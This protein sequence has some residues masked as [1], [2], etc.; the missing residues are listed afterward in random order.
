MLFLY[1]FAMANPTS[2]FRERRARIILYVLMFYILFQLVWWGYLLIGTYK[3]LYTL[4]HE[5]SE[6]EKS[7]VLQKKIWMLLGEGAVFL[8]L[9]YIGFRYLNRSLSRELQL[10]RMQKTFLLSV[11][12]ELKTPIAAIKLFLD[13]LKTRKLTEEQTTALLNDALKETKR[14]QVL[15]ENILLAQRIEGQAEEILNEK[16]DFSAMLQSEAARYSEVFNRTIVTHIDKNIVLRGDKHLLQSVCGNLLENA[17][18]Y[19]SSDTEIKVNCNQVGDKLKIEICD[20][21]IGIPDNEK[22][23]IFKKFY[24]GGNEETRS[25]KG[26]GL[27]LYIVYSVVKLHGGQIFVTDNKPTGTTMSVVFKNIP[28]DEKQ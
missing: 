5:L 23:H 27:G 11:T 4:N 20:K 15:S 3:N 19:S 2:I 21:G 22:P 28:L 24:R 9:I 6:V 14:L 18:K 8:M 1:Q 26:T 12:H 13:T 17:V 25:H 10:A 16:V 7:A